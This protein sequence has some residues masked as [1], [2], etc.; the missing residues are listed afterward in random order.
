MGL[1]LQRC[2]NCDCPGWPATYQPL[3]LGS[4]DFVVGTSPNTVTYKGDSGQM[5]TLSGY[6]TDETN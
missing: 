2:W 3:G 6:N 4:A 1:F 5:F